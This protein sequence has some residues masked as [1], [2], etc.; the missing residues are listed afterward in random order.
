M[1]LRMYADRKGWPLERVTV[2]LNHTKTHHADCTDCGPKD[3]VDVFMREV[4]IEGD[5]TDEQLARLLEIADKCP[6]HRTL[7]AAAIVETRS[8]T[9]PA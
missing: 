8:V 7:E 4:G 1:T 3:K 6:V 5:L 9:I 2:N